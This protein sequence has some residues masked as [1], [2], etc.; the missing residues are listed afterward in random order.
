MKK[1]FTR[2][3]LAGVLLCGFQNLSAQSPTEGAPVPDKSATDVV[4]VYSDAYT[5]VEGINFTP[6]WNQTT[7]VTFESVA[8]DNVMKYS[9]LNFQPTQFSPGI[10]VAAMSHFHLDIWTD[11]E[12]YLELWF[13]NWGNPT[14]V[15]VR[16]VLPTPIRY[17][18]LSLDIPLTE[19]AG[20]N[21]ANIGAI[22]FSGKGGNTIYLDNLYFFSESG[23]PPTEPQAPAATPTRDAANVVSVFSD[24]YANIA[25]DNGN[26]GG[27]TTIPSVYQLGGNDIMKLEKFNLYPITLVDHLDASNMTHLH[28]DV[29]SVERTELS[30]RLMSTGSK[31]YDVAKAINTGK[32]T[33]V[34]FE[35]SEFVNGGGLN[36]S[37]LTYIMPRGGDGKETLYFDNIYFYN[38]SLSSIGDN[39]DN[40]FGFFYDR[41]SANI[42]MSA[43][44]EITSVKV[45]NMF[46]QAVKTQVVN[47]TETVVNI[48]DVT[49]GGYIVNI[50]F[51]DG[52]YITKKIIK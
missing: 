43:S 1:S 23:M 25:I 13:V 35:L 21:M 19:F 52:S 12:E 49:V 40:G 7:V 9:N 17:G 45:Y 20:V 3:F 34:D 37:A 4:S 16:V 46:G 8:G 27:Q 50:E 33:S 18:W 5:S 29:W 47:N 39:K 2:L 11:S 30:I 6:S 48:Q 38:P 41:V 44:V 24:A 14:N 42:E 22:K 15:E 28:M 10:N 51:A 26:F 31:Q 36:Q 32:W